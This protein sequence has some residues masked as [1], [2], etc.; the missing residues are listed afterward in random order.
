MHSVVHV[1]FARAKAKVKNWK[2]NKKPTCSR[3][4]QSGTLKAK[5]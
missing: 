3:Q 4:K 5:D 1:P 2:R